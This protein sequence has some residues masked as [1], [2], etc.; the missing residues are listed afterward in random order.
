M[1]I[2]QVSFFISG[3]SLNF[4]SISNRLGI[5]PTET[6]KKNEW[7]LPS[8]EAQIA[9]DVWVYRTKRMESD[10]LTEVFDNLQLQFMPLLEI[11]KELCREYC[12]K[13]YIEASIHMVSG[14]PPF[15]GLSRDNILFLAQTGSDFG[16]D[17]YED[18]DEFDWDG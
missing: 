4:V 15:L 2:I 16:I 1:S 7:P 13:T 5:H 14:S 6:R 9:E 18:L 17:L 8:I 12:A 3:S 10:D 11:I